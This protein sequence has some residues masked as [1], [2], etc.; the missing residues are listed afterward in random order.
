VR[1]ITT[2]R[3]RALRAA[4][5]VTLGSAVL[6]VSA[7]GTDATEVGDDTSTPIDDTGT[8]DVSG[9]VTEDSNGDDAASDVSDPDGVAPDATEPDA[10]EPDATEPDATEPDVEQPDVTEPDVEQPDVEQP[11]VTE[12][13]VTEP[14]VTEPD[15]TEPDITELDATD[16]ADASPDAES[17]GCKESTDD[18]CPVECTEQN[19]YDCCMLSGEPGWCTFDPE[20]GCA[21]AVEGPFAP[22]SLPRVARP[23]RSIPMELR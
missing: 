13:D 22:P 17:P 4:H 14:D 21:C 5:A 23:L 11:D 12:P 7:C 3:A 9:D 19:D 15:V 16:A 2:N 20:W 6:F 8:G 10:T 18:V 1:T